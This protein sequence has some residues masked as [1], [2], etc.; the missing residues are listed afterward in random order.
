MSIKDDWKSGV[1]S[2]WRRHFGRVGRGHQDGRGRGEVECEDHGGGTT[3]VAL[4][5]TK[6]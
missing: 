2:S 6:S 4:S 1:G 3:L 5:P